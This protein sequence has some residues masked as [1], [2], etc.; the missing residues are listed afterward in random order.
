MF[1]DGGDKPELDRIEFHANDQDNDR[2]GFL[3]RGHPIT[4]KSFRWTEMPQALALFF[5]EYLNAG[6]A[7]RQFAF[8]GTE[9]TDTLSDAIAKSNGKLFTLFVEYLPNESFPVVRVE[10]IFDGENRHGRSDRPRS[11]FVKKDYLPHDCVEIYFEGQQIPAAKLGRF[12]EQ[13]RKVWNLPPP[14]APDFL[15]GEEKAGPAPG[16][17]ASTASDPSPKTQTPPLKEQQ[18]PAST[19]EPTPKT[20]QEAPTAHAKSAKAD[21]SCG[22]FAFELKPQ[23]AQPEKEIPFTPIDPALFQVKEKPLSWPDDMPLIEWGDGLPWTL[24]RSFEGVLIMGATG[25]GKTSG[26]GATIAETFLRSGFGGLVMT[27]KTDE[28]ERWQRLCAHSGREGDFVA[29]RRGGD[30]KLNVLAYE[31]QRPGQ[32]AGLAGNLTSFCR[33]LLRIST[34]SQGSH[35]EDPT[36]QLAGD[37]LLDATFDLFLLA[38]GG[39]TFDRLADFVA[40]APTRNLPASEADWFN[41]PVFGGVLEKAKNSIATLED[42]R[43]FDKATSYWFNVY[44]DYPGRTRSGVTLGN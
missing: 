15:T 17:E 38:G 8:F 39:I 30:W 11:V 28:A 27:A 4:E 43:L 12:T 20:E 35:S 23:V 44:R 22:K 7:G 32:G 24:K 37:Q 36:W 14:Q 3:Q 18:P 5:L 29:V 19:P 33:N 26:S 1:F 21:A 31:A 13:F 6:R 41:I 25:S 10:K 34:R 16:E 9:Q 2:F 40:A 42:K